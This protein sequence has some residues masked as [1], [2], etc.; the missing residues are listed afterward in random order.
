MT[1]QESSQAEF[2]AQHA[3]ILYGQGDRLAPLRAAL[4][5]LGHPDQAMTIIHIAGTNGKG[6]TAHM[7]SHLLQGHGFKLGLFTSPHLYT[8]RESIQINGR[9]IDK[10]AF[11]SLLERV[12]SQVADNFSQF[13]LVF[14]IAMTYFAEQDCDYVVLECGLGGELDATNAIAHSDYAVFTK[15]AR[16][17]TAMLG[18]TLSEIAKTKSG[19]MRPHQ[20][21]VVGPE[22]DSEVVDQLKGQQEDQA[23][24]QWFYQDHSQV[25]WQ[26]HS[27][28]YC[29]RLLDGQE[30]TVDLALRG[31]FQCENLSTAMLCYQV[32]LEDHDLVFDSNLVDQ[33]LSG[34]QLP[35]RFECLSEDPPIVLD[36]A[37]NPAAIAELRVTLQARFPNQRLTIVCA[38]LKDK[39]VNDLVACLSHLEADF[40]VTEADFPSR[41]L[42][43]TDL[44]EVFSDYG[45]NVAIQVNAHQAFEQAKQH[46]QASNPK[47]P[48]I[49]L[50]SFHLIKT[51]G[52]SYYGQA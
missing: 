42:P 44:A 49:V 46:S 3:E 15:I 21:V 26:A 23:D 19:I 48:V 41:R 17:H 7:L 12:N 29:L 32:W 13:E 45:I 51:I 31:S 38:F 10:A 6:S 16:D 47:Q 11:S 35:G 30:V 39:A 37:H 40:I 25:T 34:W 22:Q 2:R 24:S 18:N 50:G 9:M 8:E 33:A 1:P 52:A 43:A 36:A 5:T 28:N 4:E 20:K 14:L 27:E